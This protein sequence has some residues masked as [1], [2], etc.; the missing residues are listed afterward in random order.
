MITLTKLEADVLEHYKLSGNIRKTAASIH[1]DSSVVT[2]ICRK[3]VDYGLLYRTAHNSPYFINELPYEV[4]PNED[5]PVKRMKY[6]ISMTDYER[7]WM[8]ENYKPRKRGEAAKEL[9]RSRTEICLMAIEL[10][11]DVE[12]RW[13][14]VK[15]A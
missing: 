6:S 10:N 9:G 3:L 11:V 7:K 12:G 1:R 13:N 14:R 2:K 5:E 4:I 15:S 8:L